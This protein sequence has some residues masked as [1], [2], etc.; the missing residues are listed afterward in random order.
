MKVIYLLILINIVAYSQVILEEDIVGHHYKNGQIIVNPGNKLRNNNENYEKIKKQEFN[1]KN[2]S[3]NKIDSNISFVRHCVHSRYS[4]GESNDVT[5]NGLLAYVG[6]DVNLDKISCY[7]TIDVLS[8]NYNT[9]ALPL[10]VF[11]LPNPNVGRTNSLACSSSGNYVVATQYDSCIYLFN[12]LLGTLNWKYQMP[13]TYYAAGRVAITN[14]GDYIICSLSDRNH[15]TPH[16]KIILAFNKNSNIPIWQMEIPLD[17]SVNIGF[18]NITGIRISCND[19]LAIISNYYK[20]YVIKVS[21]GERIYW[22]W[23]NPYNHDNYGF[24]YT[25]G[26]SGDGSVLAIANYYGYVR[27]YKWSGNTYEFFWEDREMPGQYYNWIT[28]VNVSFNNSMIAAGTVNYIDYQNNIY[29]GKVKFYR[30]Y[31]GN[32]PVWV[33]AD[34]SEGITDVAFSKNEKILCAAT[35]GKYED[36]SLPNL[37]VFKT[38]ANV[39]IPIFAVSDSGS[40][41]ACSASDDG[42]TVIGSGVRPHINHWGMGGMYY[43]LYIDT[44]AEPVGIITNKNIVPEKFY[45][46]QNYPNP[47]NTKTII[48]YQLPSVGQRHAFDVLLTIYDALGRK[49]AVLVNEKQSAGSY[50]VEWDGTNYSSGLYFYKLECNE[51]IDVK[52]MVLIK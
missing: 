22:N 16:S 47:F 14:S 12:G 37:L 1:D 11:N 39:N 48:N 40:F 7:N 27:V 13:F 44:S 19:S 6:W 5:G 26:I 33:Y 18:Q 29:G 20:F 49:S 4:S 35:R 43:N 52:K 17:S 50:N 25:Q 15:L 41:Y 34:S 28:C 46:S 21:N 2:Y 8:C 24:E 3:Q 51:F 42:T 10:W 31:S 9:N 23:N 32:T 36:P 38:S 30:I 45:L